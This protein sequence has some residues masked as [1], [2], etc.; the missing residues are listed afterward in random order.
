M[1]GENLYE[2]LN[3]CCV[4]NIEY[5]AIFVHHDHLA[6]SFWGDSIAAGKT[7]FLHECC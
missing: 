2:I 6:N 3:D 1:Y 4:L 5:R 7:E